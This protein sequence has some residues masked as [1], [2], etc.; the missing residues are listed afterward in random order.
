MIP[1]DPTD[2]RLRERTTASFAVSLIVHA[3]VA[4]LFFALVTSSSQQSSPESSEGSPVVIAS[5]VRVSQRTKSVPPVVKLP[6]THAPRIGKPLARPVLAGHK[7]AFSRR[8][9]SKQNPSAPPDPTPVPPAPL[10]PN[11]Q[12]TQVA[13]VA[14]PAPV[15]Y[16]AV[17]VNIPTAAPVVAQR[18][19]TPEPSLAPPTTAPTSKPSPAPVAPATAK[20]VKVTP[21]PTA[22]PTR[23]PA[24]AAPRE[25]VQASPAPQKTAEGVP[26]PR[27]T[28]VPTT[29][30]QRG[31]SPTA[32]P[33]ALASP[34]RAPQAPVKSRPA[35]P[36]PIALPPPTPTPAPTPRPRPTKT[37][38]PKKQQAY[39]D[40]NAR[41]R[42]M[43]PSGPVTPTTTRF[44]PGASGAYFGDPT[45][46]PQVLAV[47]KFTYVAG[48]HK[49]MFGNAQNDR[50]IMYVKSTRRIGP[51]TL[52][53][54]WLLIFPSPQA[55]Y[56]QI[57]MQNGKLQTNPA[58]RPDN[59]IQPEIQES[60]TIDCPA[61][62]LQPYRPR[63][64][65]APSSTP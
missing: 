1:K 51:A 9:L 19:L 26:S 34:G 22:A 37:V 56:G 48:P 40:L 25:P 62:Q 2:Q 14:R 20:P 29:S 64:S 53:T 46:P 23:V 13:V 59:N 32:G 44:S 21:Q 17:P 10:S 3:L 28:G 58:P 27:P 41:L 54:G 61:G 15:Q 35:P 52:C 8:E 5:H 57:N 24:T 31:V 65:P 16:P 30:P 60:A 7:P 4:L 49:H 6:L 38:P 11:P 36:K 42:G 50:M 45:P 33:K 55:S 18:A 47:T 12:P 63:T 43:L 39:S